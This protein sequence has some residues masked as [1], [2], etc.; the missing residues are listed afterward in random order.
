MKLGEET[1][2][3]PMVTEGTA[4]WAGGMGAHLMPSLHH[5]RQ[6]SE[7]PTAL[8]I[9]LGT[10]SGTLLSGLNPKLYHLLMV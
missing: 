4:V 7:I 5:Q 2:H 1:C 3:L 9:Q 6:D 8:P 10:E